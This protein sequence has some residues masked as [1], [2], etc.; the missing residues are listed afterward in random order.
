MNR[1]QP[2]TIR[3][4]APMRTDDIVLKPY[5]ICAEGRST[6]AMEAVT[7]QALPA[8]AASELPSLPHRGLGY[9]IL[10]AGEEADWLLTRVW[11]EGDIVAGLLATLKDG[12]LEPVT[13]PLIECVWEAVVGADERDAWVRRMMVERPDPQAYLDDRLADGPH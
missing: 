2:R 5:V 7:A 11:L 3:A 4:F 10:H 12:R 9:L 13:A 1:Y 6:P 8:L